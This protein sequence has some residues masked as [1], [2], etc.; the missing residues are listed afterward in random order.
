MEM[1]SFTTIV[2]KHSGSSDELAERAAEST[3]EVLGQ[4]LIRSDQR[5]LARQLPAPLADA[6]QRHRPNG[7]FELETF[8]DR[9]EVGEEV[10]GALQL[11]HAQAVCQALAETVDSEMRTRIVN[12]LPDGYEHLFD[13]REIPAARRRRQRKSSENSNKLS[14]GR[15][16]SSKPLSEAQSGAAHS[17]SVVESENPRGDRKLSTGQ[18]SPHEGR[19][20]ATGRPDGQVPADPREEH[21][22]STE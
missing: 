1:Q 21:S 7:T 2:Q 6:V 9:I 11:E 5:A 20:L 19:D 18:G 3:V 15:P 22:E 13:V 12:H 17:N 14:S 10:E 8:Y 16:G 4:L